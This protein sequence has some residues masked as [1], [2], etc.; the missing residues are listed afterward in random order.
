MPTEE[1]AAAA[2]AD[3]TIVLE[4]DGT[5]ASDGK[6]TQQTDLPRNTRKRR[7]N[8]RRARNRRAVF[9][10]DKE[11]CCWVPK[12]Y[13]LIGKQAHS[14]ASRLVDSTKQFKSLFKGARCRFSTRM[15]R[16]IIAY[17]LAAAGT[18][19]YGGQS[20][21][22]GTLKALNDEMEWGLTDDELANGA[23]GPITLANWEY[24]LAAR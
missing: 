9:V 18:S 14:T 21:I 2:T 7:R 10:L 20:V 11:R 1:D 4:D 5:A 15:K 8:T 3:G 13:M 16:T 6:P 17:S 22:F 24:D 19:D 23:P 12:Y